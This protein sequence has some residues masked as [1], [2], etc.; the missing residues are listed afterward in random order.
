MRKCHGTRPDSSKCSKVSASFPQLVPVECREEPWKSG[1]PQSK[2]PWTPNWFPK[3][4]PPH[5]CP[6]GLP[7]RTAR[8]GGNTVS[9]ETRGLGATGPVLP[10]AWGVLARPWPLLSSAGQWVTEPRPRGSGGGSGRS[11]RAGSSRIAHAG[12]GGWG[13]ACGSG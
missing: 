5:G 2:L 9:G 10:F 7:C 6:H 11:P 4:P 13:R 1:N 12:V 3:P 8:E